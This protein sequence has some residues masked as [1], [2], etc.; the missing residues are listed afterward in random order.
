MRWG[1]EDYSYDDWSWGGENYYM[2][3]GHIIMMMERGGV[4]RQGGEKLGQW[5]PR[6]TQAEIPRELLITR[7]TSP[8]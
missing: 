1:N 6:Q 8:K 2:G 5:D 4:E 7:I 3:S